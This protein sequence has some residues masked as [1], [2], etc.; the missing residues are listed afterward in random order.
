M[1][2]WSESYFVRSA[3]AVLQAFTDAEGMIEVKQ[4]PF[5]GGAQKKRNRKKCVGKAFS[6]TATMM[7]SQEVSSRG[8]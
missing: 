8:G 1:R 5:L 7:V 6:T 4:R 2:R 3:V